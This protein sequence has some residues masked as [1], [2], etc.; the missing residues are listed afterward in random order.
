MCPHRLTNTISYDPD[1][2]HIMRQSFD[3][4]WACIAPRISD[5]QQGIGTARTKLAD[6]VLHAASHGVVSTEDLTKRV[7]DIVYKPRTAV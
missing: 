6:T 2:I 1:Q 3:A 7:L 5:K 4:V